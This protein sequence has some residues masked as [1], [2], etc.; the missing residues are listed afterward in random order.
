MVV[1]NILIRHF[2]L[3]ILIPNLRFISIKIRFKYFILIGCK[4]NDHLHV[5]NIIK[6]YDENNFH[7]RQ[8]K[9]DW[10]VQKLRM[11]E[12]YV[13]GDFRFSYDFFYISHSMVVIF[14]QCKYRHPSKNVFIYTN[15]SNKVLKVKTIFRTTQKSLF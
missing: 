7:V 4:E 5:W 14:L 2:S 8:Y 13:H 10:Q 6:R 15:T 12:S 11:A 3:N 9:L 1:W